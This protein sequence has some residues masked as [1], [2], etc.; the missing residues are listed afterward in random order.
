MARTVFIKLGAIGDMVQCLPALR[1]LKAGRPGV[2]L[3]VVTM[4]WSA[5]LLQLCPEIDEVIPAPGPGEG[6]IL[7]RLWSWGSIIR[8]LRASHPDLVVV[9][10]RNRMAM[11]VAWLTGAPE[12]IGFDY[13][14]HGWKLTRSVPFQVED[15]EVDRYAAL[16]EA[17]GFPVPDRYPRMR[18]APE[19]QEAIRLKFGFRPE[20]KYLVIHVSGG[21][22]PGTAMLIKRWEALKWAELCD[23]FIEDRPC[24][25]VLIGSKDESQAVEEVIQAMNQPSVVNL[26]GRLTVEELAVVLSVCQG[27]VGG[28]SGPLHLAAA[29]GLHTVGIFGPSDPRL[30]APRGPNHRVAW[31]RV[32]CAPCYTPKSVWE[33]QDF[34]SCPIGT[35]VCMKELE[36]DKVWKVVKEMLEEKV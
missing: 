34:S 15:H 36:V 13:R 21:V 10:H 17:A 25:I 7:G 16:V 27:F 18:M 20:W 2:P 12:R 5:P 30:V 3:T 23:R 31:H 19:R 1:A 8:N 33:G 4:R 35:H 29:L 9:G 14:G 11:K 28:D 22:N 32:P 24:H 6:G 26:T